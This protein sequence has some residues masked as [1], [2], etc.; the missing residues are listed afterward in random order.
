MRGWALEKMK[1]ACVMWEGLDYLYNEVKKE[2]E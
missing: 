2:N 1:L